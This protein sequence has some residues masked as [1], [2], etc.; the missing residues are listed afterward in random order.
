MTLRK[1]SAR[2]ALHS[3]LAWSLNGFGLAV[4]LFR[5]PPAG[6]RAFPGGEVAC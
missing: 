4:G 2:L 5:L 3:L 1:R 6:T